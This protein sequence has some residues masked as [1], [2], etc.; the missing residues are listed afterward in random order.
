M[1]RSRIVINGS[2]GDDDDDANNG[3]EGN[4]HG[5]GN[6]GVSDVCYH[7]TFNF[8]WIKNALRCKAN[9]F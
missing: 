7:E 8:F 2:S 5:R 9:N 4:T 1:L 6:H 3:N